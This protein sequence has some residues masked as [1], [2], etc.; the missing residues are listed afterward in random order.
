MT[1]SIDT[2]IPDPG[3]PV[4]SAPIRGNFQA[5]ANDINALQSGSIA[6]QAEITALQAQTSTSVT[7]VTHE[8][9]LANSRCLVAGTNMS[10]VDGGP[11]GTLTL[12]ATDAETGT[13]TSVGMTGDGVVFNSSVS[14]SPI[15]TSGT[16]APSL[17]T[18]TK[19]TI[20][21]GPATGSNA[22][23][24]F[25]TL[26]GADLPNPA[27]TTLG[28]VESKAAV[29]HNFLTQIGTDGS[30]AQAQPAFTDI[31]GTATT[32][33]GG[34]GQ[35]FSASTGVVQVL[36]GTASASTALA[37]GTTAT[38]QSAA[39][40][41]TKLA[42]TAYA[43]SAVSSKALTNTHILVG[44]GSN[45]ATDVAM[46][47][48]ATIANTGAVTVA[49]VNGVTYGASPSTNTVPVV[50]GTNTISYETVPNAALANSSVTIGSTNIALGATSTTLAGLTA[51][52]ATTFTG[53]LA[54]NAATS[55]TST[56]IQ[57]QTEAADTTC[58][59]VFVTD[60][61]TQALPGKT[62]TGLTYNASTGALGAT[63]F[64][65]A[66]SG[67][68]STATALQN[69]RTIGGVSF[70]G[71]VNIVP[72]TIQSVNEASDT[73][74]FPLFIND[75]GSVSDQPKNST[76]L[77]F[78]ASTGAL[79]S[80]SFSGAGTG[81]T[82]TAASLTSGAASAVAVGGITGLGTS[83]AT[84]LAVNVGTAGSP[85]VNGGVLGTPSSGIASNL[86]SATLSSY[87]NST[88]LATAAYAENTAVANGY[89]FVNLFRNA[90]MNIAQRGTALTNLVVGTPTYT[91]DG[92]IGI[93][94]GAA[95]QWTRAAINN[96]GCYWA[97]DLLGQT[98]NTDLAVKQ[99]IEGS[100]WAY[101]AGRMVLVQATISNFTGSTLTPKLTV[102]NATAIDNWTSTTTIVNAVNLQSIANGATGT[103]AYAYLDT[104]GAQNGGEVTFDFGAQSSN[105]N[106][107]YFYAPDVRYAPNATAGL[108]SN[109]PPPELRPISVEMTMNQRYFYS[110]FGNGVT[111][112][113]SGGVTNAITIKNPIALGD[114]SIYIEYPVQMR[115]TP[116]VTTYNPSSA[117]ANWRDITASSDVTVSVNSPSTAGPSGTILATSGTVTTLGD[118]LAI[119]LTAS[120]EL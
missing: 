25:R 7:T 43:D 63:S 83:V 120:A 29:T 112:A 41:S 70:D 109:P 52:T 16:L 47:G 69:A 58:F 115:S 95:G 59:P 2:T 54:G 84:A 72:Q 8:A 80:T 94:T 119:H 104:G 68:A 40:N 20:L 49:K 66:F 30:V 73:T 111:P 37:N 18:Q 1:S 75:S 77:T 33:Q 74:C 89:G 48:D 107:I 21:A 93:T 97:L 61:G 39:D 85:V 114:P 3:Q 44:N 87:S 79:G 116:S 91:L 31:S 14:G 99:R 62:N 26:V 67:N 100:I 6:Q 106:Q 36:S 60:S 78:N 92:W 9:S 50:T 55:T 98:S 45:V 34:T 38:T 81:L 57:T 88:S 101:I 118:Y 42:T 4:A 32:T 22:A 110:S 64:S 71:T 56:N 12:N 35:N 103:V 15:T 96:N 105:S 46:S 65:G 86:T 113:Q 53:T 117:N 24:T 10:F 76:A 19:N 102:K 82:G 51:V 28:G 17:A 13:V 90:S 11:G 108:I 5:A 27:P 23:P